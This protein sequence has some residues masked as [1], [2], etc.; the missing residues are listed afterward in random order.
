[1]MP[2]TPW[3]GAVGRYEYGPLLRG[4]NLG[5]GGSGLNTFLSLGVG[6]RASHDGGTILS[7]AA[8]CSRKP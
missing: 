6:G 4:P 1:M 5:Q 8:L 7:K 3:P 2:W